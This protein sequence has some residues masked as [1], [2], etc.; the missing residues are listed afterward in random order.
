MI[1]D[2]HG[3]LDP[4]VL[5][6]F[7]GVEGIVHAGD[8]GSP[9]VLA[10]LR[11]VAPVTVVRGNVD[12][13]AWAWDLPLE[14]RLTVAGRTLL[15]GHIREAL[16]AAHDPV[17]EGVAAVIVGHSHKPLVEWREGILYLNPGSAGNRR[18][19][20]P[21]AVALL[22][23]GPTVLRPQIIILEEGSPGR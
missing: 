7:A 21:R 1:S 4:A 2:T 18:F 19:H 17:A 11:P 6:L 20:L 9:D 15:V 13:D 23:V 5:D 14:A 8:V 3:R 12:R 16:L 10:G 22:D